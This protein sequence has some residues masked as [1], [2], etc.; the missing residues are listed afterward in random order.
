M[1][2]WL[3]DVDHILRGEATRLGMLREERLKIPLGG[4]LLVILL[5]AILYGVC[6]G[7]FAGFR[8]GGPFFRQWF[9]GAVKVPSLFFLTL[10]VATRPTPTKEMCHASIS[11]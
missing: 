3:K 8:D 11:I 6:M 1:Q 7:F 9:A 10:A 4:V 5:M 2:R